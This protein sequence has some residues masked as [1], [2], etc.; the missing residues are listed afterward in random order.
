MRASHS[1]AMA[2]TLDDLYRSPDHYLHAFDRD[3]AVFVPMDRAAYRR[4]TFL[5]KRI[6]PAGSGTMRMPVAA[7]V[8]GLRLPLATCWIFHMAHG[9]STLLSR[10]L[11]RADANLVLREPFALRQTGLAPDATRLSIALA[12]L[13]K[14]YRS[15]APTLIKANVPVNF[16]LPEIAAADPSARAIFL[17]MPLKPYL[18]AVL[19][20]ADHRAWVRTV[21]TQLAGYLGDMATLPDAERA[22]ALWL[23]QMRHFKAAMV[24]MPAARSLDPDELFLAPRDVLAVAARHFGIAMDAAAIDETVDGPLFSHHAKRPDEP[25]GNAERLARRA[26]LEAEIGEELAA[27]EAWVARNGGD[28]TLE[29]ALA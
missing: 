18:L 2:L 10:S 13:G 12:M 9:G 14:R 21:T 11:D 15:D 5:D 29:R 8:P 16:I 3:E 1:V 28:V 20:S 25:F 17:A 4:S 22:A 23:A 27:A 7:L 6:I 19:R 26:T 24:F